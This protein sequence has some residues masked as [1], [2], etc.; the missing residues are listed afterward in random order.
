[1]M[2][3][4][5]CPTF[6]QLRTNTLQSPRASLP[7]PYSACTTLWLCPKV[8]PS[9]IMVLT[10]NSLHICNVCNPI[11]CRRSSTSFTHSVGCCIVAAKTECEMGCIGT[12]TERKLH[13]RSVSAPK[14]QPKPCFGPSLPQLDASSLEVFKNRLDKFK[15]SNELASWA[16]KAD[17]LLSP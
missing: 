6:P 10:Q 7:S 16:I 14:Q 15:D 8:H 4:S 13:F 17:C 12:E 1:M 11:Q 5:R 9:S 3:V 2:S